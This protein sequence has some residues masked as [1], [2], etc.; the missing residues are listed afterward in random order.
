MPVSMMPPPHPAGDRGAR[1]G[2]RAKASSQTQVQPSL[3]GQAGVQS[4]RLSALQQKN[5]ERKRKSKEKPS[6]C[7]TASSNNHVYKHSE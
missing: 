3:E 2:F 6:G 4:A 7:V 1:Q 5:K